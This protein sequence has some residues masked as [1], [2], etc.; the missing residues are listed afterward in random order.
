MQTTK[1]NIIRRLS[2]SGGMDNLKKAFISNH[3]NNDSAEP[4]AKDTSN[5][6]KDN[7][8]LSVIQP[9]QFSSIEEIVKL[10]G[11]KDIT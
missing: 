8:I 11:G 1:F 6:K 3:N 9:Q 5:Q 4:I 2:S 7:Y 10:F